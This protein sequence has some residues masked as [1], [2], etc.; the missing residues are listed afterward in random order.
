MPVAGEKVRRERRWTS[1]GVTPAR[2]LVRSTQAQM[3]SPARAVQGVVL[4]ESLRSHRVS[5]WIAPAPGRST[6]R[7]QRVRCNASSSPRLRS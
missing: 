4:S 1:A 5:S 7:G 6:T 3:R 2:E